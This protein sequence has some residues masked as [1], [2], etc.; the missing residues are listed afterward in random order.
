M[1]SCQSESYV[2]Q[3]WCC[4]FATWWSQHSNIAFLMWGFLKAWKLDAKPDCWKS[5]GCPDECINCNS[6]EM[7]NIVELLEENVE[8]FFK[9]LDKRH[10]LSAAYWRNR[11]L[12][13]RRK[14]KPLGLS[15]SMCCMWTFVLVYALH[16]HMYLTLR[17][18]MLRCHFLR[19]NTKWPEMT[20]K[21]DT[22]G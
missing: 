10:L 18:P 9:K 17:V 11:A 15:R 13:T 20:R 3:L 22:K 14:W 19:D 7:F 12:Q 4:C 8:G 1:I 2:W 6:Q 21:G 16:S 5:K